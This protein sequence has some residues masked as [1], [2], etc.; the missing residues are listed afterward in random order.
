MILFHMPG[1]CSLGI[2]L[3]LEELG[4]DY[5]LRIIDLSRGEQFSP[6]FRAINPKGK[7]PA[8]LRDDGTLITEFQAVAF[9]LA[10]TNPKANLLPD[11]VEAQCRAMELMDYIVGTVHMRGYTLARLP[12][13]FT[14]N[15]DGQA[16]IRAAGMKTYTEG[17]GHLSEMLGENPY[18]LGTFSIAD[19]AAFYITNWAGLLNVT[20]PANLMAF[21]ER[22]RVRPA[23]ARALRQVTGPRSD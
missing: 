13:K 16:D 7:V 4:V 17:I 21:V 3:L 10:R 11:E 6:A 18:F 23:V 12:Q 9:W 14:G 5:E 19:A 8:L 15:D 22:M 1:A 2:H 20:L